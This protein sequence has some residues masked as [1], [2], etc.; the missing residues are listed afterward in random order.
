MHTRT[1]SSPQEIPSERISVAEIL[2]NVIIGLTVS[3]IALSLGAAL[4]ILSGRGAFAGMI[5]AGIIAFVTACLGGTR[6]QC[7]GPTAPMSAVSA[8]V[9]AFT[10]E[11]F[12]T[13]GLGVQAHQFV[14]VVVVLCGVLLLLMAVLKLGRFI[15]LVPNV[16]VS[17]FMSGIALLIWVDQADVLMGWAGKTALAGPQ[18]QNLAIAVGTLLLIFLL[19]PLTRRIVG[20]LTRFLPSTLLAIIIM[21]GISNGMNFPIEHVTLNGGFSSLQEFTVMLKGQ[22][23]SHWSGALFAAALPFAL[24]LALLCYLDTLLTSLVVDRMSGERTGRNRELMAQGVGNS[25]VAFVGGIPG[26]QATIRSVLMLKENATL[27]LSGIMVGVFVLIEMVLFQDWINLIPKAVFVGVLFKVGYDVF[28]FKPMRLYGKQWAKHRSAMLKQFFSRHDDEQIFV[29]N[30]ELLMILGTT[31]VT[32]W[33]DL[34]IAVGGFTLLFYLHNK[35]LNRP[36]PMRDL[37]PEIETDGFAKQN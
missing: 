2:Q 23:P 22:V 35:W 20:P 33:C 19:A 17:G 24:Q 1:S 31:A 9:V 4:G 34:N 26:A 18:W 10:H 11:Q 6:V 28:D 27:R 12:T 30:R 5:S 14:N 3:F 29:T 8:V 37:K 21:T 13:L 36:N 7:S 32:V 16:V 15:A 25:L